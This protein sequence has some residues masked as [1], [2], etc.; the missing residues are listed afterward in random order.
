MRPQKSWSDFALGSL[1]LTMLGGLVLRLSFVQGTP[2]FLVGFDLRQ[3]HTHLG[4]YGFLIPMAW[5]LLSDRN[6]W[7][8]TGAWEKGYKI[9]VVIAVCGFFIAGYGPVAHAFSFLVLMVWLSF[10]IKNIKFH[11]PVRKS[12]L[13]SVPVGIIGATVA[14]ALVVVSAVLKQPDVS[15][16]FV[17][18]FL[19]VLAYA[20][21]L[22][23]A[24]DK[25]GHA[26]R[27]AW[28]WVLGTIGL[29]VFVMDLDYSNY[30]FWGPV[31][32]SVLLLEGVF[33]K[34]N[35]GRGD[36][37]L[38]LLSVGLFFFGT[39]FLK[40]THFTVVAGM[41]FLIFGPLVSNF[42]KFKNRYQSVLYD[43]CVFIMTSALLLMDM[44]TRY[45]FIWQQVSLFSGVGIL[46][47]ILLVH[48]GQLL[49]KMDGL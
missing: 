44:W 22:P 27:P 2:G 33:N 26:K 11:P 12:W 7:V 46:V 32:M 36:L 4:Y 24:I 21:I 38:G 40:N 37:Y 45:F 9:S 18:A 31:L 10:A 42:I 43:G 28:L 30:F 5:H 8:P 19:T 3:A 14:L 16:R 23:V 48:K 39:T 49:R 13:A 25:L 15:K 20:V 17:R 41:H 47:C 34:K 6:F 35:R 1:I 29:A